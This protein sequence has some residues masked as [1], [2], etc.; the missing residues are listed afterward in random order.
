MRLKSI[1]IQ[2]FKS[3]AEKVKIELSDGITA[4]VGPNG[5]GKSN[6]SDAIRWVLGEQSARVLRGN[7]MEDIIFNGAEDRKPLSFAQVDLVFDNED[8]TM[9]LPHTEVCVSRRVYRSG[10]SEYLINMKPCRMKDINELFYDTG[11][12]KDGYS[13]IGQGKIEEILSTKGEERRTALEEAAGVMKFKVRKEEAQRKLNNVA[14]SMVRVQ[15]IM[16]EIES[17]LEPLKLQSDQA[18]EF[19]Q[20]RDELKHL[21]INLFLEQYER[22]RAKVERLQQTIKELL[23]GEEKY[24]NKEI[25]QKEQEAIDQEKSGLLDQLIARA[26]EKEVQMASSSQQIAGEFGLVEQRKGFVEQETQRLEEEISHS[27]Q[28]KTE[29]LEA[30]NSQA[31]LPENAIMLLAKQAEQAQVEL[32]MVSDQVEALENQLDTLKQQLMDSINAQSESRSNLARMDAMMGQASSRIQEMEEKQ[33]EMEEEISSLEKECETAKQAYEVL[34]V[35]RNALQNE[36]TYAQN[37][38]QTA[39]I[40]AKNKLKAAQ[41]ADVKLRTAQHRLKVQEELKKDFEGYANSVKNLLRDVRQNRVSA[42]VFGT[43][44]DLLSVPQEYEKAMEQALGGGLQNVVVEREE[45]AKALISHLRQNRYGR[46]TFLPV[47]ALRPRTFSDQEL[48][49]LTGPGVIGSAVSLVQFDPTVR[50]AIEYLLGR[51][52]VVRDMDAGIALC[53]QNRFSFRCVTMEGDILNAAGPITGGSTRETNLIS[54]D[55]LIEDAKKIVASLQKE[56]EDAKAAAKQQ[57]TTAQQAQEDAQQAQKELFALSSDIAVSSERLDATLHHT[58]Q[59]KQS[60]EQLLAQK[61]QALAMVSDLKRELELRGQTVEIDENAV[62]ERIAQLSEQLSSKKKDREA[63]IEKSSALKMELFSMQSEATA[64]KNDVQRAKKE[65]SRLDQEITAKQNR[66]ESLQQEYQTISLDLEKISQNQSFAQ[67]EMQE[68]RSA[69]DQLETEREGLLA[70]VRASSFEREQIQS[71]IS[72]SIERRYK[73]TSQIERLD[74]DFENLQNRIWTD[75]EISY[76]NAQELRVEIKV[77]AAIQRVNEIREAIRQMEYVNPG[78]I[79]EYER[80]FSRYEFLS[81]QMQDL[82][83]A[84]ANLEELIAD[85]M[86]HMKIQF[87]EQFDIINENFQRIFKKLFGGGQAELVLTDR[88]NAMDCAIDIVAQ[89][90]GKKLQLITLLSGGERALTA[91]AILFALLELKATPFCILD[92]IETS[93]D[94]GNLDLFA[95]YLAEYSAKTQFIVITHRRQS[96]EVASAMYGISMQEKGVSKLV[97]VKFQGQ[98]ENAHAG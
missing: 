48:R 85:L 14:Q 53:R 64:L 19:I 5:S 16:L 2:G 96:M 59:T 95:A 80:M 21:E 9:K 57:E 86:E 36:M 87:L 54:R 17:N 24:R 23:D 94:E 76:Q 88:E 4:I 25:A 26:H 81:T 39:Q 51:T 47:S 32:D 65:I 84:K 70:K 71:A 45:D 60:Y 78:A 98:G 61:E 18:K 31:E 30:M 43:V 44:G 75:Y 91:I 52:I 56:S 50:T 42:K 62:K 20:L 73:L 97:S 93:L 13:I 34:V 35:R 11:V 58:E 27:K 83:E 49:Q 37:Q 55:R 77:N 8:G 82:S 22:N 38:A 12:G 66:L 68:N 29:L 41:E 3:F 33:R 1:E 67:K 28:M 46:V 6:V 74:A 10:E 90:P 15:D 92:E 7:K 40:D 69:I 72:E 79:E 63:Q 89:P